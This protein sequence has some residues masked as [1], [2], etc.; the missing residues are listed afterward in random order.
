[1]RPALFVPLVLLPC[2]ACSGDA[3]N[4]GA[5][6][7]TAFARDSAGIE[8]VENPA[9]AAD[10][11][12]RW[13]L[14]DA[15]DV[16]IGVVDGSPEYQLDQV[17]GALRLSDGRIVA[18]NNGSK[19]LRFF[20]AG[21]TYLRSA[22]GEGEGPGEFQTIRGLYRLAGDSLLVW[23][24]R[25]KRASVM[26][27]QGEFVRSFQPQG[28]TGMFPEVAG[29]LPDGSFYLGRGFDPA[30]MGGLPDGEMRDSVRFTRYDRTGAPVD[31]VGPFLGDEQFLLKTDNSFSFTRPVFGRSFEMVA[32]P[33]H[34]Y[35]GSTDDFQITQFSP[36]GAPLRI[37]RLAHEPYTVTEADLER[38][39][40]NRSATFVDAPAGMR[41]TLERQ[42]EEERER[43]P[44]RP[45]LPAYAGL[46]VDAEG[47]LWVR[48]AQPP[49]EQPQTWS[50]FAPDGRW[51]AAA[52]TPPRFRVTDIGRDWVL[53][54]ATDDLE[55][56]HVQLYPLSRG[57]P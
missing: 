3:G 16:D 45:T 48:N 56:Q 40:E 28:E 35:A 38:Y 22:G 21:G 10:A 6:T 52:E 11:S 47:Y 33:E 54:V 53:G 25:A 27:P 23:D 18:A 57:E 50:V 41:A 24:A 29:A 37:I 7:A 2:I 13:A 4:A 9:P 14:G 8:I 42:A 49:G 20:D 15:P 51:A 17:T 55:V 26:D 1:M 30:R 31:T 39:W 5:G 36:A 32:A 12:P 46:Q 19:E 34:L 43:L 44:Y